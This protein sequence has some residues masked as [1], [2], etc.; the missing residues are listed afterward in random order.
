MKVRGITGY[1]DPVG[2]AADWQGKGVGK[3]IL[4]AG[5]D[6]LHKTGSEASTPG[7]Q[8]REYWYAKGGKAVGFRLT[9]EK[10]WLHL[11]FPE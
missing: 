8:F 7:N 2:V 9:A 3:A 4:A 11:S 1:T 10:V 5:V 6:C